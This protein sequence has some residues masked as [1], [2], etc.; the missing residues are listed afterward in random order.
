MQLSVIIVSYNVRYFI[1]QC[2]DSLFRSSQ[3]DSETL[4]QSI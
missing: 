2:L 1:R 3:A 4:D